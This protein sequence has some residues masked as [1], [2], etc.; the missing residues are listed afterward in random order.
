[1]NQRRDPIRVSGKVVRKELKDYGKGRD[2]EANEI[3]S[4]TLKL[5]GAIKGTMT[6][7]P[8][9]EDFEG[10]DLGDKASFNLEFT[11]QKLDLNSRAA[12]RREAAASKH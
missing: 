2:A 4:I 9:D 11:Q 1:M 12:S 8:P 7:A 3:G 5:D 6:I 10:I